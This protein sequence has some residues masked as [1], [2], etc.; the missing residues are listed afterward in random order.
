MYITQHHNVICRALSAL[1]SIGR[2]T[3]CFPGNIQ[4]L[5]KFVINPAVSLLRGVAGVLTDT[6]A[7][8]AAIFGIQA[9]SESTP[10]SN[11]ILDP[12]RSTSDFLQDLLNVGNSLNPPFGSSIVDRLG[13]LDIGTPQWLDG[14]LDVFGRLGD[15]TTRDAREQLS[16]F[17]DRAIRGIN[18][19]LDAG[20][21]GVGPARSDLADVLESFTDGV[22][23]ALD[24]FNSPLNL[25][26]FTSPDFFGRP[27]GDLIDSVR[28]GVSSLNLNFLGNAYDRALD[29]FDAGNLIGS[30]SIA[31]IEDL[32]DLAGDGEL[33]EL[34]ELVQN[35]LDL[36]D[37]QTS[38]QQLRAAGD[39][40][41]RFRAAFDA[42][43]FD[44]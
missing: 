18:E 3:S 11:V 16:D 9:D 7:A 22:D 36:S 41:N 20:P 29:A 37:F 13:S 23:G 21:L 28:D 1:P 12:F 5:D 24:L 25:F 15:A 39:L 17:G 6:L 4:G 30:T 10:P 14:V 44:P 33:R 34:R 42:N 35:S 43:F 40:F 8:P 26:P 31:A 38:G 27:G 19:F 2:L 32:V